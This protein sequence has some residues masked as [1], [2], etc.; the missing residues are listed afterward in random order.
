[1][2]NVILMTGVI[3]T[4]SGSSMAAPIIRSGSAADAA[5]LLAIVD[6]HRTDLGNP[7]NGVGGGPF[8]AGRREINWDAAALDPFAFPNNMPNN[9]FNRVAQPGAAG[10]PRGAEFSTPDGDGFYVS[11]RDAGGNAANPNNRF[12]DINPQYNSIFK[13][14]SQQ[15]LFA[16]DGG[17]VTDV[18][19]FVPSDPTVAATVNGFGAVFSDVDSDASTLIEYFDLSNNLLYSQ[20]VTPRD[21]GLSFLGVTFDAGERVAR[22]RITSG[23]AALDAANN[24]GALSDAFGTIDVVAMDDFFYGEPIAVPAPASFAML[25]VAGAVALRRRRR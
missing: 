19:F 16:V 7:N 10:S 1:M 20:N 8:L 4:A 12:G 9:F 15:R 24:D 25:G 5:G 14:F 18:H 23:N 22:V 21:E 3:L 11:F 2:K 13:T 6:A 17:V